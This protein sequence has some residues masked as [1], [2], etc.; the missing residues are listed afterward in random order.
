MK[1]HF[2]FGKRMDMGIL[3]KASTM[4]NYKY[5]RVIGFAIGQMCFGLVWRTKN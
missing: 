3:H 1:I 4:C 2:Q 5:V